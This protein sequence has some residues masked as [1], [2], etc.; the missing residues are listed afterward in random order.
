MKKALIIILLIPI[1]SFSQE[2]K[3]FFGAQIGLFEGHIYSEFNI[4][5]PFSIRTSVNLNGGIE[6]GEAIVYFK[7]EIQPRWYYN[8]PKR[9]REEKN[10]AFNSANYLGLSVSYIPS[11]KPLKNSEVRISESI[12]IIPTYGIKRNFSKNFNYECFFGIGYSRILDNRIIS[13]GRNSVG[14]KLGF[15]MG[16]DF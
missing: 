5:E 8:L 4:Q 10:T 7:G 11:T 12:E 2:K 3:S 1:L 13:S 9:I 14:I 6:S 16:F 15:L